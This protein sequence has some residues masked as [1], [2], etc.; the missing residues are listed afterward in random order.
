MRAFI[1]K[2]LLADAEEIEVSS[3]EGRV[4]SRVETLTP[5]GNSRKRWTPAKAPTGLGNSG[6]LP[7]RRSM[8]RK[9]TARR[10]TVRA[11]GG[12]AGMRHHDRGGK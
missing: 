12:L 2:D 6:T 3:T 7:K 5:S 1:R 8:S 4:D 10:R 9:R 11:R